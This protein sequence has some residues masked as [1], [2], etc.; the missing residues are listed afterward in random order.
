MTVL[1]VFF[2]VKELDPLAALR[3]SNRCANGAS[4]SHATTA[5]GSFVRL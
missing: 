1:A 4:C 3:H 5:N 2:M